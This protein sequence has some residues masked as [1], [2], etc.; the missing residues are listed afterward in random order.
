MSNKALQQ[1]NDQHYTQ[2][3]DSDAWFKVTDV[4]YQFLLNAMDWKNN[5]RIAATDN[6][7][8]LLDVG[9][10]TGRFPEMLRA[11]LPSDIV[12]EY[13]LVDPVQACLDQTS[14][15]LTPPYQPA[16]QFNLTV[17]DFLQTP[18]EQSFD[19]IWSIH[20]FY[21]VPPQ[22]LTNLLSELLSRLTDHGMAIFYLSNE[23]SFYNQFYQTFVEE[24]QPEHPVYLTAEL[25]HEAAL[26]TGY[27]ISLSVLDFDHKIAIDDDETLAKY[28]SKNS[29]QNKS[30]EQWQQMQS[31]WNFIQKFAYHDNYRFPQTVTYFVI[32]RA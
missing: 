20:S 30:I 15:I 14:K 12:V 17:Q 19:I 7:V 25:F 4:D 22:Q 23:F 32:R 6:L 28:L 11:Y 10:G 2:H 29:F 1:Q 26:A 9:C 8:R 3:F 18:H 31:T 13:N 21:L 27:E 5:F 16:K 24:A